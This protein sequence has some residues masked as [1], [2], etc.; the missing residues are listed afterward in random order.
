MI[1]CS[2]HRLPK[3]IALGDE[4]QYRSGFR[5]L[6][7]GKFTLA[8][9]RWGT[10]IR[11]WGAISHT[12]RSQLEQWPVVSRDRPMAKGDGRASP[13]MPSRLFVHPCPQ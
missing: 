12:R 4:A 9:H 11:A 8:T 13:A 2:I 5:R 3:V 7:W 1:E 10:K 6:L